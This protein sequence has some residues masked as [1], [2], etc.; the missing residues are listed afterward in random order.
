M[1]KQRV[2]VTMRKGLVF[3]IVLSYNE[4][5]DLRLLEKAVNTIKFGNK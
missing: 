5:D 3:M 4:D 2:Y 1:Y